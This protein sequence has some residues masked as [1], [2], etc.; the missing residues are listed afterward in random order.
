NLDDVFQ[1]VQSRVQPAIA[2]QYEV[3]G[4]T[5]TGSQGYAENL[6]R[7][8]TEGFAP[9]ALQ[10]AQQN[11][12]NRLQATGQLQNAFESGQG[13]ALSAAGLAGQLGQG[14]IATRLAGAG[15]LQGA[16][17]NNL[18]NLLAGGSLAGQIGAQNLASQF[19]GAQAQQ[20]AYAD[21]LARLQQS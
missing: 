11:I 4:R 3:A 21:Q 19:S 9:Y 12:Q 20:S 1:S 6:S 14:D 13:R 18:Q 2:S 16:F 7:G 17:Q 10:A 8:L 5:P 15:G